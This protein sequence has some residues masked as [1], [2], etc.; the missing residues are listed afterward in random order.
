MQAAADQ[1]LGRLDHRDRLVVD[2]DRAE[3]LPGLLRCYFG[4]ATFLS[5]EPQDRF[6][7]R[8]DAARRRVTMWPLR[9]PKALFPETD[10]SVRIDLRRQDVNVR[11]DRRRLVAK[12]DLLGLGPRTKQRKLET[13]FRQQLG[14]ESQTIWQRLE[15]RSLAAAP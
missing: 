3:D 5:G 4:C 7:L 1:G 6:V 8:I 14:L 2:G 10:L 15:D 11:A 9:D 13:E 12:S